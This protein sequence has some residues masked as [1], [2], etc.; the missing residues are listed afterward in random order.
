[1]LRA[2]YHAVMKMHTKLSVAAGCAA[3]MLSI[4]CEDKS[5]PTANEWPAVP[6]TPTTAADPAPRTADQGTG[7]T[8]SPRESA[9]VQDGD[10]V[11]IGG[12]LWEIPENWE[13]VGA[14]GMRIAEY[15]V[16]GES[17][18]AS[19]RFFATQGSAE[20]NVDRWKGQVRDP[21]D[22][23]QTK[24]IKSGAITSHVVTVTGTY[25]GMGPSGAPTPPA[26]GTRML[27]AFVEGGPRPVQL[28]ITGPD[29]I[30]RA[31]EA[32]WE[33]MLSNLRVR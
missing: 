23:P 11:D 17:G 4:G 26:S 28:L 7:D 16:S 30:V 31:M 5:A 25:S 19:I 2:G 33:S 22:G 12:L 27:G 15:K 9:P 14:S 6:T 32:E 8:S 20:A 3:L 10:G 21:S 1:M 29:E 24:E 18:V 13:N